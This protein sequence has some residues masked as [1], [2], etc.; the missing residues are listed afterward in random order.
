MQSLAKRTRGIARLIYFPF[1]ALALLVV[2]RSELFDN[3]TWPWTLV[4]TQGLSAALI[5]GSVVSLRL[6]AEKARAVACEHLNAKIIEAEGDQGADGRAKRLQK[7]V[8]QIDGLNEGA[9]A[10]WWN[11]PVVKAVLLPLLTY[12]GTTL[13]H[14]Y[15]L[16][17]S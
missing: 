13:V 3:F 15:A 6:A 7:L 17:G 14:L 9:F 2:S 1:I 12:G 11:Q 10:P 8:E 4:V 16:P 5:I